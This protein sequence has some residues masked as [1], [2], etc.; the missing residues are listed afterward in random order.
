MQHRT[1]AGAL[2]RWVEYVEFAVRSRGIVSRL[3]TRWMLQSVAKAFESW[4]LVV[5]GAL[6]R[7][8]MLSKVLYRFNHAGMAAAFEGWRASIFTS[9]RQK[10]VAMKVLARMQHMALAGSLG[11]WVEFRQ[12]CMRLRRVV[13]RLAQMRTGRCWSSWLEA[14]STW[15]AERTASAHS[16]KLVYCNDIHR[17]Q[18]L[19]TFLRLRM[20]RKLALC[21]HMWIQTTKKSSAMIRTMHQVV[22]RLLYRRIHVIFTNWAEYIAENIALGPLVQN[23]RRHMLLWKLGKVFGTWAHMHMHETMA[24][25]AVQ[26]EMDNKMTHFAEAISRQVTEYGPR[27]VIVV[28]SHL[29][30][31][32]VLIKA[33]QT[34]IPVV[35]LDYEL[36]SPDSVLTSIS[37]AGNG[38]KLDSIAFMDHGSPGKMNF[39]C[40]LDLTLESLTTNKTV[41]KFFVGIGALMS[42]TG[43]I[44]LLSCSVSDTDAGKDF[45]WALEEVTG[46]TIA[47]STSNVGATGGDGSWVL[48][49]GVESG[50]NGSVDTADEYFAPTILNWHHVLSSTWDLTSAGG[51]PAGGVP[52]DLPIAAATRGGI[53]GGN[54]DKATMER[55]QMR[56][57]MRRAAAKQ[58]HVAA[59]VCAD[60]HLVAKNSALS[61]RG[62]LHMQSGK[63]R[64]QA[65]LKGALQ[66]WRHLVDVRRRHQAMLGP[67]LRMQFDNFTRWCGPPVHYFRTWS[68]YLL[69]LGLAIMGF[70]YNMR[71]CSVLFA[72]VS[73]V[74]LQREAR[75]KAVSLHEISSLTEE[76]E[77]LA[78]RLM[79]FEAVA[80]EFIP[81]FHTV[82]IEEAEVHA[83]QRL[84]E[85]QNQIEEA[86]ARLAGGEGGGGEAAWLAEQPLSLEPASSNES[87]PNHR[88]VVAEVVSGAVVSAEVVSANSFP[89]LLEKLQ[90][91]PGPWH[92][93]AITQVGVTRTLEASASPYASD[94][95]PEHVHEYGP[96]EIVSVHELRQTLGGSHRGKTAHG[97]VSLL[98]LLGNI[99]ATPQPNGEVLW[100]HS[101]SL[102]NEDAPSDRSPA[103]D[104]FDEERLVAQA[105]YDAAS[106]T[107]WLNWFGLEE[108]QT[109]PGGQL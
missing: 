12:D 70:K 22:A 29:E 79:E 60:L 15:V 87:T 10:S 43:R 98:S 52:V 101:P 59:N 47:A 40:D 104:N 54:T 71:G 50:T 8:K 4:H 13:L 48:D 9:K 62:Y 25:R 11:R 68:I 81:N 102:L 33:V 23:M 67:L 3:V 74:R 35:F 83:F 95:E 14:V 65:L 2:G 58:K 57:A 36:D 66:G 27:K 61:L 49:H 21:M 20:K 16:A 103:A 6:H 82:T 77:R 42:D 90:E 17:K 34:D 44:D 107:S 63:L 51:V 72:W 75:A 99:R 7:K 5:S 93:R 100:E 55:L 56:L 69:L 85:L 109:S 73:E 96:G 78:Q 24:K 31:V 106:Q 92:F 94:G 32:M 1:I 46:C 28:S 41:H 30:D 26:M 91:T 86:E 97:W 88:R 45:V 53:G 80:A 19:F 84:E 76:N 39:F 89:A 18:L 64:K 108:A 105:D 38:H 37:A